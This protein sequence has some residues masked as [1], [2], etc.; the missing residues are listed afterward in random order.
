MFVRELRCVFL[1]VNIDCL[2]RLNRGFDGM[3]V[4][5][6]VHVR[7][8]SIMISD[9]GGVHMRASG[10][11]Q[12]LC[13]SVSGVFSRHDGDGRLMRAGGKNNQHPL[14]CSCRIYTSSMDRV[15]GRCSQLP[16]ASDLIVPRYPHV[17]GTWCGAP[18]RVADPTM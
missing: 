9:S 12:T 11:T 16:V 6:L 13:L 5:R 14:A 2:I 10:E 8:F 18:S 4:F 1:L 3:E 15:C 7:R 17:P